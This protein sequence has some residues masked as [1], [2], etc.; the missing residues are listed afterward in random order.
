MNKLFYV[1][2][3]HVQVDPDLHIISEF[4]KISNKIIMKY[5]SPKKTEN[6]TYGLVLINVMNDLSLNWIGRLWL[7]DWE[8]GLS[9]LQQ[10][11]VKG[12]ENFAL[13]TN[14]KYWR[15]K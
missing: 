9:D 1:F 15:L 11:K 5:H 8:P 3:V 2:Y 4:F 10:A 6:R 7:A 14:S 13:N 12:I